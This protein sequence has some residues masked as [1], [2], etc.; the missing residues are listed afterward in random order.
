MRTNRK[1]MIV[2]VAAAVISSLIGVL[3]VKLW[4]PKPFEPE[5]PRIVTHF[6]IG[7]IKS[8]GDKL[9]IPELNDDKKLAINAFKK[10]NYD[11]AK[12]NWKKSLERSEDLYFNDPEALIY[13]NNALAYSA[14]QI[15][16]SL[17]IIK[18][19]V[20]VPITGKL[21][22]AKQILRGVAQAQNEA[23]EKGINS[24]FSIKFVVVIIN[25]ANDPET[26]K[27]VAEYLVKDYTITGVIG[28]NASSVSEVTAPIYQENHLVMISPTSTSTKLGVVGK[29]IFRTVQNSNK[30]AEAASNYIVQTIGKNKK[31]GVCFDSEDPASVSS[32]EEFI[33][34]LNGSDLE[35]VNINCDMSK[36]NAN[37]FVANKIFKEMKEAQVE[38]LF[39]A[40][41]INNIDR[42]I[43]TIS[44]SKNKF[45]LL[46]SDSTLYDIDVLKNGDKV[47][48]MGL[49]VPWAYSGKSNFAEKAKQLWKTPYV[50]WRTATSYNAALVMLW[51]LSNN[52]NRDA[53]QQVLSNMKSSIKPPQG[54][55]QEIRFQGQNWGQDPVIVQVKKSD[56]TGRSGQGYDFELSNDGDNKI[57]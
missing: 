52:N 30:Q 43:D 26:G 36:N 27:K 18:I 44:A 10:S 5:L 48:G 1:E 22:V 9:L 37:S 29:Y 33:S 31:V 6:D 57:R 7:E 16:K 55:D 42:A 38:A 32:K 51:G 23:N 53:L 2:L 56:G 40:A 12:N 11:E 50:N 49:V 3:L 54:A 28:H 34:A 15:N 8:E 47:G 13:K 4:V 35:L 21:D 45:S 41:N 39:V 17:K 19:A 46:M 25:D 14:N 20:V 24:N